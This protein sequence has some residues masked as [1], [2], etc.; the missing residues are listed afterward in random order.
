MYSHSK[1]STYEQCPYK[2]KLSYIDK[3]KVD[4]PTTIEAF[5]GSVVHQALEQL[6]KDKQYRKRISKATLLKFYRE[7]WERTYSSDILIVK[8]ISAQNYQKMGEKYLSDYYE[9]YKPFEEI[10]ILGLET[11]D[12]LTL[13]DGNKYHVRIDKFGY[14]DDIYYVCD[15]KTN[16]SMKNQEEVDADR[17]L[18]MYSI[19]V[20][21]KFK[22]AKKVIL[23]W[24]MLAF[25]KEITSERN[26]EQ[27]EKLQKEVITQIKEIETAKAFPTK[28]SYLC[29]YCV[30]KGICPSFKHEVT[31]KQKTLQ[32]FKQ[33]DGVKL[34]DAFS[35]VK[36]KVSALEEK[37]EELREELINYALQFK[38]DV[39]YGS[40]QKASVKEF[41]KIVL[42]EEKTQFIQLLKDKGIYE[43]YSMINYSRLNSKIIKGDLKEIKE[44]VK[45]EKDFRV[46]LSKKKG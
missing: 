17:Q 31:L 18:A 34:V 29:N 21:D 36:N 42:P 41:E 25:N 12:T 2:Y 23:K 46:S 44:Q 7:L 45:I 33:D 28:V 11:Q 27:L 14:K 37:K 4:I 40:N 9:K 6:Y 24:H 8:N 22:D 32:E 16:L 1:I 43:D 10:T 20:K 3:I 19:W 26:E 30:Y 13:P 35:D 39:V 15:Y 5:M 38:I